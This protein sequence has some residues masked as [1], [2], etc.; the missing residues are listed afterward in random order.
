MFVHPSF[1]DLQQS[2]N[3]AT[4][5]TYEI[6]QK[7]AQAVHKDQLQ[8]RN[9]LIRTRAR[10]VYQY[11]NNQLTR[12]IMTN[13]WR[14]NSLSHLC[15]IPCRTAASGNSFYDMYPSLAGHHDAVLASPNMLLRQGFQHLAWTQR[16]RFDIEPSTNLIAVHPDIG[17]PTAEEVVS[18]F[19]P[20]FEGMNL[21]VHFPGFASSHPSH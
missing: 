14:W 17:V 6:F 4:S 5:V 7:C 8:D 15:F 12:E 2:L 18:I 19:T 10:T 21:T 20:I 3:V 16:T 11:Y 1:Q 9:H 13:Q